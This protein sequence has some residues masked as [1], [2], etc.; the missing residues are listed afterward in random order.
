MDSSKISCN[1][2]VAKIVDETVPVDNDFIMSILNKM[3][4]DGVDQ[5]LFV[6]TINTI[7]TYEKDDLTEEEKKA[8][9]VVVSILK[10]E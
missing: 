3:D 1:I 8:F 2:T 7:N 6:N 10:E 9:K 4:F 5:P